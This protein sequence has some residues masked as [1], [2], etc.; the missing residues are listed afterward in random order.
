MFQFAGGKNGDSVGDGYY[1]STTINRKR[2]YGVLIS[3]E[4]LRQASDIFFQDEA[5]SLE[6]NKRMA[7]LQQKQISPEHEDDTKGKNNFCIKLDNKKIDETHQVQK[8]KY[9]DETTSTSGYRVILATYANILE[10]SNGD[11]ELFEK[12]KVACDEGGNWVGKYYY[13]YEVSGHC[14]CLK[15]QS[16]ITSN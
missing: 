12:I 9:C 10:A 6:I 1:V 8:F 16:P 11:D 13:Q 3:Q 15:R 4:A 14:S 5:L 7:F 2:Y